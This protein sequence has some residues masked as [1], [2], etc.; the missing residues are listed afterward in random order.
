MHSASI[1]LFRILTMSCVLSACALGCHSAPA[2]TNPVPDRGPMVLDS[3]PGA[4]WAFGGVVGQRVDANLNYW[5]LCAPAANPGML[6]M[7]RVRDRKPEPQLVPWAG[8]FAGKY[9][10]SAVQALR[11]TDSPP[12]RAQMTGFVAELLAAQDKDGYIG[13]FPRAQR[14]L[15]NWDLWGHYH[16]MEGLLLWYEQTGDPAALAG[17]QRAA[18]LVCH[19]YLDQ[20][21]R[22][23]DA[24]SH[25]MN[26]AIIHG[27]GMLYRHTS[28]PRYLRMMREIE[29]DWERA[30]DYLRTGM[31]G[32]DFFATPS[33]RW[34]SLHDLQGLVELWRITGE[35]KYRDAFVHHW[36]SIARWDRHNTGG[37]SSGEQATGDAYSPSAIETCCT[38]AWMAISVDMLRLTGDPRVADEL[39][40]STLNGALAAQHPSGRWWTYNTPM[41][42]VREAS[43]HTI[44]FQSRAGTPELNCCSVNG[45]RALGILSEWAAMADADGLVVNWHGPGES[46]LNLAD[47]TPVRL[48]C[49]SD[50][51]LSGRVKWAVGLGANP[52]RFAIRIRIPAW[53]AN[54]TVKLNG[55]G[56]PGVTAGRYFDCERLW[57]SGDTLDLELDMAVR[58]VPGDREAAGKVSLYRGPILLAYDQRDNDFDEPELPL[59]DLT[60]LREA[61][62]V[63]L[64]PGG[65]HDVANPWLLVELPGTRTLRLRDFASAGATGTRY[66]SWLSAANPP[67]PPPVTRVPA[68]GAVIGAG[69]TAFRWTTRTNAALADYSLII[70]ASPDSAQPIFEQ[71]NVKRSRLDLDEGMKARLEPGHWYYWR[72]IARG[73]HGQTRSVEPSARFMFDPAQP[74]KAE[75]AEVAVGPEGLVVNAP[76]HGEAKP[77]FG[78]LKRATACAAANGPDDSPKGA[79]RLN[80][81]DQML[82]YALPE[83]I[84][85]DFS[86]S[87]WFR[88]G[89]MPQGRIAQVFSAWATSMDDPLRLT[90]DGGKLFARVEAQQAY[91]TKGV[92]MEAGVWHHVAAVKSGS[93]L[94]LFVDGQRRESATVPRFVSPAARTCALGGN[95]NYSGN[96]FLAADFSAFTLSL[97]A[98]SE[99]EIKTLSNT[100]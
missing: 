92:P 77:D 16:V 29:K 48:R 95:P 58:F 67:P 52:R 90:L 17:C 87:L 85:E 51:P 27:L 93:T 91:G 70:S 89:S 79:V 80:G 42:G 46:A 86:V 71:R 64:P 10:I 74:Q 44:V 100:R 41:D 23:F 98:F 19:T 97:R 94:T 6:E 32:V 69:K 3:L 9:L 81:L 99:N 62:V 30:G 35:T 7:F 2:A 49:E 47:G 61:R 13:P 54:T 34:E 82:I 50:F 5:L 1:S 84:E 15:G 78:I 40:L 28:E 37:F 83:E 96:E 43:A 22:V 18:D 88:I 59:V 36:R 55:A 39:E 75:E 73:P 76:L 20:P 26:M 72:V 21:R 12:L 33:P 60:R 63:P 25:E 65:A 53:S 68:D 56:L 24:D 57:K 45:P 38:I 14:L 8:E 31:A 4:R 66:R 11:M